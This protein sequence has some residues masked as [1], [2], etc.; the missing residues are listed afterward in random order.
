M[1]IFSFGITISVCLPAET[2]TYGLLLN[3]W[4]GVVSQRI[5]SIRTRV[6]ISKCIFR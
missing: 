4:M 5:V 6:E 2:N 1:L 3:L